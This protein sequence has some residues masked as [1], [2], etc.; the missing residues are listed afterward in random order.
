MVGASKEVEGHMI[1]TR[2]VAA[3]PVTNVLYHDNVFL[4]HV[5]YTC[6]IFCFFSS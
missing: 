3:L 5:V 4:V 1:L 6:I 2:R